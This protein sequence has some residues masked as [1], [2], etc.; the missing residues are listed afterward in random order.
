LM[1]PSSSNDE[2]WCAGSSIGR[3]HT[4]KPTDIINASPIRTI[5]RHSL[6]LL[7]GF[8]PRENRPLN[9]KQTCC[10]VLQECRSEFLNGFTAI[11][12]KQSFQ[13]VHVNGV[14]NCSY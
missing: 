6:C 5:R 7:R 9:C 12:G 2:Q 10:H 13:R 8:W 11:A 1:T 14:L 3:S 4:S